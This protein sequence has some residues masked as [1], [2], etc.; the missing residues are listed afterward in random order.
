GVSFIGSENYSLTS[1]TKNREVGA[2]IFE[3]TQTQIVK[4]RFDA[5]WASSP[6]IP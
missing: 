1:L 5:D 2:L 4:T 6:P 3:P